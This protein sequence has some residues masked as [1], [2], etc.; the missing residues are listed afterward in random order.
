MASRRKNIRK[1][2]RAARRK[3]TIAHLPKRTR[4]A[5]GKEASKAA[6]RKKRKS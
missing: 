5:L 2:A 3:R 4:R 1:A 6:K